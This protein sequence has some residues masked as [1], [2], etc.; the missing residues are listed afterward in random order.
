MPSC[1]STRR[2]TL[3]LPLAVA[4]GC[5]TTVDL[6][7]DDND[8]FTPSG[9][10]SYEIW[11]GNDTRRHGTLLDLVWPSSSSDPAQAVT[12]RNSGIRP[13]ISIDGAFARVDGRDTQ[14]LALGVPANNL[15]GVRG[16][17]SG[18]MPHFSKQLTD[19]QISAIVE[20]E[21]SL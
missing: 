1:C 16:I 17:S 10:V 13:T 3:L 12:V 21:R 5:T 8:R 11:P 4:L 7:I 15:Y 2:L 18:R 20:Y 19:E 9:R 6:K 14:D